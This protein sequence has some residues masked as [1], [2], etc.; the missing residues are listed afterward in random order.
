LDTG[1]G[2]YTYRFIGWILVQVYIQVYRLDN[3]SGLNTDLEARY[4][5]RFINRFI[6]W[7]LVQVYIYRFIGWILVQV[8]IQVNKLDTGSG[9]NTALEARYWF[10]FIYTGL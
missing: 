2:L 8:Y 9:L 3:G 1:S 4:R 7:I 5:F 6:G 10:R